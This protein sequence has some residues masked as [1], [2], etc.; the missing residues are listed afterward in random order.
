MHIQH[1]RRSVIVI[2]KFSTLSH[3]TPKFYSYFSYEWLNGSIHKIWQ[4][5]RAGVEDSLLHICW[6]QFKETLKDLPINVDL[7]LYSLGLGI[8]LYFFLIFF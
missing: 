6:P 8:Q 2:E 5:Q 7:D 4:S 3:W 1:N